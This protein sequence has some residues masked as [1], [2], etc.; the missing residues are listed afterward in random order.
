MGKAVTISIAGKS[1]FAREQWE[2]EKNETALK[3]AEAQRMGDAM[4]E[5]RKVAAEAAQEQRAE[6]NLH[7]REERETER[8]RLE[9]D[10]QVHKDNVQRE[11]E[12]RASRV[13]EQQNFMALMFGKK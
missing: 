6:D 7:R 11:K 8:Q 9:W 5:E 13:Q 2:H 4:R 10:K 1:A 3:V 12:E